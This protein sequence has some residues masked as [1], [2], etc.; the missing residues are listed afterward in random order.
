MVTSQ[1]APPSRLADSTSIQNAA[2]SSRMPPNELKT[3]LEHAAILLGLAPTTRTPAAAASRP[4]HLAQLLRDRLDAYYAATSAPVNDASTE[5][6]QELDEV[7]A[8]QLQTGREALIALERIATIVRERPSSSSSSHNAATAAAPPPPPLF[9]ARDVKVLGMLG[10]VIGKWALLDPEPAAATVKSKSK[11]PRPARQE[12]KIVELPADVDDQDQKRDTV[13]GAPGSR[14]PERWTTA[15]RVLRALG[16]FPNLDPK[17]KNGVRTDGEKQLV[18]LVLPQLLAPL[19]R[20]LVQ[21]SSSTAMDIKLGADASASAASY[22]QVV[23]SSIQTATVISTLLSLLPSV[24]PS[25]PLRRALSAQLSAQLVR[26]TGVRALLLVLVGTGAASGGSDEDVDVRKLE[27]IRRVVET[28][29][30]DVPEETRSLAQTYFRNVVDQMLAI[31]RLAAESS[32][33]ATLDAD[34]ASKGKAP[35]TPATNVPVPIIR[36]TCYLLAHLLVRRTSAPDQKEDTAR[37]IVRE[38]LHA[39][40]L[41]LAYPSSTDSPLQPQSLAIHLSV[42]SLLG[43]YAPPLPTFLAALLHPVLAPLL[44]LLSHLNHPPMIVSNPTPRAD[45]LRKVISDEADALVQTLAKGLPA[46][47]AVLALAGAVER[48]ETGEEFGRLPGSQLEH[49]GTSPRW[50]WRWTQEGLPSL[51]ESENDNREDDLAGGDPEEITEADVDELIGSALSPVDIPFVVELLRSL[52]RKELSAGLLLRWLDELK[53]LRSDSS[54][55]NGLGGARRAVTRLQLVLQMVEHLD[56]QEILKDR[57]KEIIAFVAHA[58]DADVDEA[59]ANSRD[60]FG[61][62]P[63]SPPGLAGIHIIDPDGATSSTSSGRLP[64]PVADEDDSE[65]GLGTGLGKDEMALTALTLLLAVL[66]ADP[67]LDM[68]NT[69]LLAV[70]YSQL[71]ALSQSTS[72]AM[73]PPLAREARMVLSLRRAS[74]SFAAPATADESTDPLAASRS[75]YREALKLL[76]DP[77]LPVRA[78]GLTLL[79]SLVLDRSTALLSTDPALLPAVLDIFVQA[80]EE[81]DSFLYLN[82]VQGLSSLVDVYG[83]RVIGQLLEI[84][85]GAK[86]GDREPKAIGAGEQGQRELDKRLR[87]GETLVQVIQRAGEA[88]AV[89]VDDLIPPLMLVLRT[90][91]L[92]VPLRASAITILATA[93]ETAPTAFVPF[94]EVLTEACITLLSIETV[95]LA[96]RPP[97]TPSAQPAASPSVKASP[98][99]RVLIE[100]VDDQSSDEEELSDPETSHVPQAPSPSERLRKPEEMPN[101][102]GSSPKHPTLRRAA[103]VFLGSLVRTLLTLQI[104]QREAEERQAWQSAEARLDGGLTSIRMPFQ[105][106]AN[107]AGFTIRPRTST[108]S[109]TYISTEQLVRARTVLR[110][111][112]E[113]DEDALVRDQTATVLHELQDM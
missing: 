101:P 25:S 5:G 105:S 71:E 61:A 16:F 96:A 6:E 52:D 42:L 100:E 57:P 92:P 53:T 63:V 74:S 112:S 77:L 109:Q 17:E 83:K 7:I 19:V 12:A 51:Q 29:P 15:E 75:K 30:D 99:K 91:T 39:P 27:M 70:V 38:A 11:P 49:G 111:V 85:T 110:Y 54:F 69:P 56:A 1:A 14:L 2:M 82:A 34:T 48:W 103:A 95:P 24:P 43:I 40:L 22:L 80:I 26:P 89:F 64:I 23:F 106:D 20:T 102:T 60:E 46:S 67:A 66:E 76:Q 55:A 33:T 79:R 98:P 32:V 93:V 59:S 62:K 104:E 107:E 78:Q 9:G 45:A 86:K 108:R 13:G 73:I 97:A 58:L 3:S 81:E 18:A 94:A 36:A 21:V 88:L 84:Y 65:H 47:E 8:V 28:R 37:R 113:T 72:S 87:M 90:P 35:A 4:A 44:A 68:S 41:P 50:R 10:G 31:L